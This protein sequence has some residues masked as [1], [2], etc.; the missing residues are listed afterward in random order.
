MKPSKKKE[1]P[2]PEHF[3]LAD[4][5]ITELPRRG[6]LLF[7]TVRPPSSACTGMLHK[8]FARLC[9]KYT[10]HF[11]SVQEWG[12]TPKNL[13]RLPGYGDYGEHVHAIV[14]V[15]DDELFLR[16]VHAWAD[17]VTVHDEPRDVQFVRGWLRYRDQGKTDRLR[18]DIAR[19]ARYV[20]KPGQRERD[21]TTHAVARG[22]FASGWS[23][24][25][26][27]TTLRGSVTSPSFCPVCANP[28]VPRPVRDR[29]GRPR[30]FCNGTCRQ[31]ANRH[32]HL[33]D[34]YRRYVLISGRT[35]VRLVR[36][37]GRANTRATVE[38]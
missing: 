15:R 33:R 16:G 2:R 22:L 14:W 7:I 27:A 34:P 19:M 6:K 36:V 11:L 4:A 38:Q 37:P 13:T 5:I 8:D 26:N 10:K 35:G 24:F 1:L 3:A 32:R 31:R 9:A 25:C 18:W 12:S 23:E 20:T 29:G 28:H 30:V 21:F 17:Q